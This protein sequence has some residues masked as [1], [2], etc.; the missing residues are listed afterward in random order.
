MFHSDQ[1]NSMYSNTYSDDMYENKAYFMCGEKPKK[2]FMLQTFLQ[3]YK[4][5][6]SK[7]EW[8]FVTFLV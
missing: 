7:I 3:V 5:I 4:S 1:R 2:T 8:P 6:K